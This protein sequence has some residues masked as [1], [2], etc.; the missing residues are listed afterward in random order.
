MK[1]MKARPFPCERPLDAESLPQNMGVIWKK[2][3]RNSLQ[4]LLRW[5]HFP[6]ERPLDAQ[7][8]PQN[9]G[10][11]WKKNQGI[12][13]NDCSVGCTLRRFPSVNTR[14]SLARYVLVEASIMTF[15]ACLRPSLWRKFLLLRI[16]TLCTPFAITISAIYFPSTPFSSFIKKN[17]VTK[18]RT[19]FSC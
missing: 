13:C 14:S 7:S 16:P 2:K 8:L 4:W 5:L 19:H 1:Q 9:M 17:I 3:P 10:V 15:H 18:W 12:P 11:I 6:C